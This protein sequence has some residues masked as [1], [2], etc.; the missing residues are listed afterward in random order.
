MKGGKEEVRHFHAGRDDAKSTGWYKRITTGTSRQS[1][2]QEMHIKADLSS[3][4]S[5]MPF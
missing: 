2:L 4:G 5:S 3:Q 1:S